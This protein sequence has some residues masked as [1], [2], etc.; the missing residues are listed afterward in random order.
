MYTIKPTVDTVYKYALSTAWDLSTAYYDDGYYATSNNAKVQ[1][2][3]DGLK[4]FTFSGSTDRVY[5][6]NLSE[7][8]NIETAVATG[9]DL[10]TS[11]VDTFVYSFTFNDDG[12]R[13]YIIG[14]TTHK[15]YSYTL[16][17]P[18]DL[19]TAVVDAS[20]SPLVN[21]SFDFTS[22]LTGDAREIAFSTDGTKMY[23]MDDDATT[24]PVKI[25]QYTLS[26]AWDITSATYDGVSTSLMY[27]YDT[28]P[29]NL[30]FKA[31]GTKLFMVGYNNFRVFQFSMS[32]PWDLSTLTFDNTSVVVVSTFGSLQM[33]SIASDGMNLY[34]GTSSGLYQYPMK[35]AWDITSASSK[36]TTFI[37]TG[38][39]LPYAIQSS[40]DGTKI[41]VL[42][43]D[44]KAIYQFNLSVAWDISTATFA[45]VYYL[46]DVMTPRSFAFSNGSGTQMQVLGNNNVIYQYTLS[47]AWSISTA[48]YDS[49]S[50][51]M[52]DKDAV[53]SSIAYNTEDYSQRYL[54]GAGKEIIYEYLT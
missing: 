20:G 7:A 54:Y 34:Y 16:S 43:Q 31:D 28:S 3:S 47:V 41:Y 52:E 44:T 25:Y 23:I 33:L 51:N 45:N 14:N 38:E 12:T 32:T 13:L 27:S 1:F 40:V 39:S 21:D 6:F 22:Q 10:I 17:I 19:S 29:Q 36:S 9:N 49:I 35:T 48:S 18:Y 42:G 30:M 4:M 24:V 53:M 2:K 37:A 5:T 15:V 26:I 50:T 11:G 46:G 8:W